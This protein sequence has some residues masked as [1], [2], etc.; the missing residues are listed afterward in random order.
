MS[1]SAETP[2]KKVLIVQ[3]N[4][5]IL[6]DRRHEAQTTE[7]SSRLK[8]PAKKRKGKKRKGKKAARVEEE[9]LYDD[10]SIVLVDEPTV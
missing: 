10:D 6:I 9:Q 4:L 1:L 8:K 2:I 3:A 7:I 5:E